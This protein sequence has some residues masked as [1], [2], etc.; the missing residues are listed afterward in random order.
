MI[1]VTQSSL[2]WKL[3]SWPLKA[4]WTKTSRYVEFCGANFSTFS[5][6]L[7]HLLLAAAS[8]V[9]CAGQVYL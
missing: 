4:I 8:E 7:A 5:I 2:H 9:D 6:E 1:N 3:F